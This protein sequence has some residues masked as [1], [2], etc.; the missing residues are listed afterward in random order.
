MLPVVLLLEFPLK[1]TVAVTVAVS[2]TSAVAVD[3]LKVMDL[4]NKVALE[5]GADMSPNPSAATN[6]SA[7]RLKNV[8]VDIYFLS[9]VVHETFSHTAG[10]EKIPTS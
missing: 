1:R 5:L 6:P 9:L 4:V 10:R 3:E 8:F 2:P 7:V